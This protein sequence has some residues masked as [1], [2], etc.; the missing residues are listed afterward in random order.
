MLPCEV[1]EPAE[2]ATA[3]VIWLHGLGASGHDFEPIV[4]HVAVP[5]LRFVFPHAP[6]APVT[7]NGGYVMPSWYD[8][9]SL[10]HR[11]KDRED[12]AGVRASSVAV[13]EL[14]AREVGRGIPESRVLLAGFSQGGAMALHCGLRRPTPLAGVLVLSGYLVLTDTVETEMTAAAKATPFWFGHGTRDEVVP[15]AGGRA[16]YDRVTAL[17]VSATWHDWPIGHEVS[18][19]E[20]RAIRTFF[21]S[22]LG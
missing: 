11:S 1:H 7:I 3:A 9:R 15:V 10:D 20:V 16:S 4:P 19:D 8:I 2:A 6:E 17:G 12:P 22:R 5:G 14:I 21:A 18:G 13:G